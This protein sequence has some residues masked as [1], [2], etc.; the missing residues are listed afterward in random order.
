[1]LLISQLLDLC[2]QIR[3]HIPELKKHVLIVEQDHLRSKMRDLLEHDFP[4]L[5]AVLPSHSKKAQNRDSFHFN[6]ALMFFVLQRAQ[7]SAD[8]NDLDHF[9]QTQSI[10]QM[11]EEFLTLP[12]EGLCG[13]LKDY[14]P[15][16]VNIDPEYNFCDCDGY[17]ISFNLKTR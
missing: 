14:E 11:L 17:S 6:N 12:P 1:M 16:T 2:T 10:I 7:R 8:E 4:L 15:D 3:T 9:I 13:L 5:V